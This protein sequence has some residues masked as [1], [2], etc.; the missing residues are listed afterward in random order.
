M[1]PYAWLLAFLLPVIAPA[2]APKPFDWPQWQG[3]DRTAMSKQ[4]G[5]L[6]DW[7]Q[8]GPPLA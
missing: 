7:P 6:K 2:G 3:P 1:H 8:D 4:T 5:L